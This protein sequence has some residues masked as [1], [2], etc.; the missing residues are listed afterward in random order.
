MQVCS[1]RRN[2]VQH[3]VSSFGNTFGQ[4]LRRNAG[5]LQVQKKGSLEYIWNFRS[6]FGSSE[7]MKAETMQIR[8]EGLSEGCLQVFGG[9][10]KERRKGRKNV[11]LDIKKFACLFG[12]NEVLKKVGKKGSL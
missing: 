12:K 11:H 9:F 7:E 8:K 10:F 3:K 5:S 6:M 1:E 4:K 2:E